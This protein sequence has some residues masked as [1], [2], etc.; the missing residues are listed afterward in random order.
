MRN[1]KDFVQLL[2]GITA[3]AVLTVAIVAAGFALLLEVLA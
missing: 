2:T 1:D 3:M